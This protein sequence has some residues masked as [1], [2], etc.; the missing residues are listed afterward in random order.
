MKARPHRPRIHGGLRRSGLR[1]AAQRKPASAAW[2][3]PRRR[4]RSATAPAAASPWSRP[5]PAADF[6]ARGGVS[7]HQ[8][9]SGRCRYPCNIKGRVLAIYG[10]ADPVTPKPMMDAFEEEM[11][12][13]K[14]DWQVMM[15]GGAV[16]SFCESD[17]EFRAD[18]LRREALP[19]VVPADAGFFRRDVVSGAR[20]LTDGAASLLRAVLPRHLS[21]P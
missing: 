19:E 12:A 1:R 15:F 4:P 9:Q 20:R 13:A 16:H 8:P 11:T 21:S 5:A 10:S 6:A 17:R 18:A 3:M 2:S 14:I 7:R